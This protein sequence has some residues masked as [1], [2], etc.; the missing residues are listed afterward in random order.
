MTTVSVGAAVCQTHSGSRQF[1]LCKTAAGDWTLPTSRLK[2]GE[3]LLVGAA[4][5]VE[6]VSGLTAA[7]LRWHP[8]PYV[9]TD[10]FHRAASSDEDSHDVVAFCFAHYD[11]ASE[12]VEPEEAFDV[13]WVKLN[14]LPQLQTGIWFSKNVLSTLHLVELLIQHG[15]LPPE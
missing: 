4:R 8:L 14:Q 6:D 11:S 9:A 7:S 15:V 5:T 13:K 10:N 2:F 3:A 1:L 12:P